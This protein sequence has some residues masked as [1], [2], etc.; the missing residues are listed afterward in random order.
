MALRL[1]KARVSPEALNP[2]RWWPLALLSWTW[3]LR[4]ESCLTNGRFFAC[5]VERLKGKLAKSLGLEGKVCDIEIYWGH[6]SN[7]P[8]VADVSASGG[9]EHLAARG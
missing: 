6:Q 4:R 1:G 7:S 2:R 5:S 9:P 3:P 8:P